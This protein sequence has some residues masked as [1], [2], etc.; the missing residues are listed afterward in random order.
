MDASENTNRCIEDE[1]RRRFSTSLLLD[2]GNKKAGKQKIGKQDFL[3]LSGIA[4]QSPFSK[5]Y[6][7]MAARSGELKAKK[8]NC[9]W[10]TTQAWLDEFGEKVS[11]RKN[12]I[13]HVLSKKMENVATEKGEEKSGKKIRRFAC[14]FPPYLF[15]GGFAVMVALFVLVVIGLVN[16]RSLEKQETGFFVVNDSLNKGVVMGEQDSSDSLRDAEVY[17]SEHFL[18]SQ[19]TFGGDI[20]PAREEEGNLEIGEIRNELV[21]SKNQNDIKLL[22]SWKTSKSASC[23]IEYGKNG[24]QKGKVKKEDHYSFAHSA[25]LPDLDPAT[26][27]SFVIKAKDKWGN[28]KESDKFAF[29]TGAPEI[30]LMELLAN[31]ARDS[32]GWAMG[33]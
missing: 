19:V 3:T 11:D 5:S 4:K 12:E 32:F 10:H 25:I 16:S 14:N 13:R 33:K 15:K 28:G 20:A 1:T 18:F 31:A 23:E 21:S 29:Y 6:L 27:Y 22:V 17:S 7:A 8:I 24:E 26:A 9:V 2:L 30:S